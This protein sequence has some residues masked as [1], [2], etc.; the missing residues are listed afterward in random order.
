MSE[1]FVFRDW[2]I[3]PEML[4]ALDRYVTKGYQPGGFLTAVL[5]HDLMEACKRA[6]DWNLPNLPAYAAYLYNEL[7]GNC[8]GSYEI[9]AH[10]VQHKATQ[11]LGKEELNETE[12][13]P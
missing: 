4:E 8:H 1:A 5:A 6:D 10:W 7:P 13:T 12:T 3:R 11:A 9:V 2:E